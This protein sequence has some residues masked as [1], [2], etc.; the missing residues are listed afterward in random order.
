MMGRCVVYR[1]FGD[2]Q[3]VLTVER[4]NLTPVTEEEVLIRMKLMPI[5]PS[6]LIPIRGAYAHRTTLP[7]V[8]GYE[9]VG[10]IEEVG[11]NGS[12]AYIGKRVLPLR[13]EGTWQDYVKMKKE[14]LVFV[15]DQIDDDAAAQMYINPLTAWVVCKE[16]LCLEPENVVI[17]NAA[18]SALGRIFAQL[19]IQIGFTLIAVVRREE[20]KKA[21]QELGATFVIDENEES[22]VDQV[23][24]ITAGKGADV[25]IDSIGGEK[26]D[27]LAGCVRAHG[28]FLAIGLL[29]GKQVDW[30]A[31]SRRLQTG[32]FHLRHWN[33]QVTLNHWHRVYNELLSVVA[34]HRLI[35]PNLGHRYS[36][37]NVTQAVKQAEPFTSRYGKVVL[38]TSK[39]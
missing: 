31:H 21:L 22:F 3:S 19:S 16:K 39:T 34:S 17:I 32:M 37:S 20:S 11:A 33:Q 27:R 29:S 4:R 30:A 6:D 12:K 14:R 15:P 13:A 25:A 38:C 5:N 36:L 8:P 23:M 9:G 7:A 26:G 1:K 10:V 35:L 24:A 2:P 28:K 18:G